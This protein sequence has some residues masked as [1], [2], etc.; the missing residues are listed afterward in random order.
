LPGG[1]AYSWAMRGEE[2]RRDYCLSKK[3][4]KE[5]QQAGM[6]GFTQGPTGEIITCNGIDPYRHVCRKTTRRAQQKASLRRNK[7]IRTQKVGGGARKAA[8][9]FLWEDS[10][11]AP[12]VHG[13]NSLQERP[14]EERGDHQSRGVIIWTGRRNGAEAAK[15]VSC[16]VK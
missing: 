2:H 10:T 9:S 13:T 12:E 3:P 8:E 6:G 7:I 5:K 14:V 16:Q 4:R 1:R 15:A 11:S